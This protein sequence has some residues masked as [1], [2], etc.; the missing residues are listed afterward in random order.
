MSEYSIGE[1]GAK[2]RAFGVYQ[3]AGDVPTFGIN[4]FDTSEWSENCVEDVIPDIKQR[5]GNRRKKGLNWLPPYFLS[6]L[7]VFQ[8]KIFEKGYVEVV[9]I[10]GGQGENYIYLEKFFGSEVLRWH[11]IEQKKN[12]RYGEKLYTS[13]NIHFY[14][15][16]SANPCCLSAEAVELLKKADICL[17][18]GVLQCFPDYFQLLKEASESGVEYIFITRTHITKSTEAFYTR[19]YVALAAGKY[20]DVILGDAVLAVI[21]YDELFQYMSA[22]GYGVCLDIHQQ[23]DFADMRGLPEQYNKCEYRDM[24]YRKNL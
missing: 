15:N 19:Y 20:K 23:G 2:E 5:I 14:E 13:E 6:L 24:L 12:C 9:D 7:P 4:V 18:I 10:G 22:L 11:V 8:C 17:M 21:N 3:T 16:K 1:I